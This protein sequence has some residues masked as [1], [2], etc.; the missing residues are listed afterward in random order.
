MRLWSLRCWDG[1]ESEDPGGASG[2]AAAGGAGIVFS[3][4]SAKQRN[5]EKH[6][7]ISGVWN[8][9]FSAVGS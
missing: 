2:S 8:L 5:R 1:K 7:C 4:F 3:G 6:G 9:M